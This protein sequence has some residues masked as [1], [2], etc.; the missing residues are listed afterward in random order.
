M[1]TMRV[2]TGVPRLVFEDQGSPLTE[3]MWSAASSF[4][5][6]RSRLAEIEAQKRAQQMAQ[7]QAGQER[8]WRQQ[9]AGQSQANWQAEMDARA[10]AAQQAQDMRTPRIQN[11]GTNNDPLLKQWDAASGQWID[12]SIQ[13]PPPSEVVPPPVDGTAAAQADGSSLWPSAGTAAGVGA[14]GLGL[15]YGKPIL[16]GLGLLPKAAAAAP[17]AAAATAA[18]PGLWS[19]IA[20]VGRGAVGGMSKAAPWLAPIMPAVKAYNADNW[21]D[22]GGAIAEGVGATGLALTNPIA[23]LAAIPAGMAI[24]DAKKEME[25]VNGGAMDVIN[26]YAT[27]QRKTEPGWLSSRMMLTFADSEGPGKLQEMNI[28][29]VVNAVSKAL[30]RPVEPGEQQQAYDAMLAKIEHLGWTDPESL[31]EFLKNRILPAPQQNR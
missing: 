4:A 29:E 14:A 3:G 13:T 17:A 18:V 27:G 11:F 9:Q 24:E 26:A 7:D 28:Q 15:A 30:P 16:K 25:P 6:M 19:R 22:R 1:P 21:W 12:P 5:D 31:K 2:S 23:S 20:G 10:A 8:M